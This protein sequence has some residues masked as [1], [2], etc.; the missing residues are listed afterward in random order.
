MPKF[1]TPHIIFFK[2]IG[3]SQEAY[4]YIRTMTDVVTAGNTAL[5]CDEDIA[6]LVTLQFA[7]N[8]REQELALHW[9]GV[10]ATGKYG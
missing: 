10:E 8:I 6:L 1:S 3:A 4:N 2:K 9:A 5:V 7:E